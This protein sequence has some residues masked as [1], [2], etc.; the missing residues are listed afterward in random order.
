[1]TVARADAERI[2]MFQK[3]TGRAQYI[4]DLPIPPN[5]LYAVPVPSRYSHARIISI[6]SSQALALPGVVGIFDRDHLDGLDPRT[7]ISQFVASGSGGPS[8]R[9]AT[10]EH[11]IPTDRVRFDGE[12]V[13]M[14]V[15]EDLATARKAASLVDVR[16]EVL[17]T[18][19]SYDEALAPGAPSLHE[20]R[21][22]NVACEDSF[23]WGDVEAGLREAD[24][25]FETAYHG[26]MVYHH[27]MEPA[28]SCVTTVK[29]D[30]VDLWTSTHM[31][32]TVATELVARMLDIP[33]ENVRVRTPFIGGGFGAKEV[34]PPIMAAIALA[35]RTGR[36]VKYLAS[37]EASF[38]SNSRHDIEYRA[39][40]G[41]KKDGSLVALDVDLRMDTGAYF[42]GAALVAR[43]ACI[44]SWGCY[45]IPHFRVRAKNVF[46]NKVP[47]SAFRGTG[48]H[49]TTLGIEGV[50]D[51][52]AHRV[53]MTPR[54]IRERNVLRRGEKV[55]DGSWRVKGVEHPADLK[56]MDTDYLELIARV[57]DAIAWDGG[58]TKNPAGV[59]TKRGRG[60]AL[61]LRHGSQGGGRANAMVAMNKKGEVHVYHNAPDL[62][63]GTFNMLNVVASRALGVPRTLVTVHM[64][65]TANKL[66]FAGTSAQRTTVQIGNAVRLACENLKKEIASAAAQ[67][68]TGSE[69]DWTVHEGRVSRGSESHTFIEVM[70]RF[71][72]HGFTLSAMGSY[73]Y[74][75][76]QDRAFGGLDHWAPGAAAVE[77]EVDTDTGDVRV[78][79]IAVAS[80]AGV[81]LHLGSVLGQAIGGAIHGIGLALFEELRYEDGQLL[82]ADPFQ[83]RLPLISDIPREFS[84]SV[85]ENGDGPG[86]FGAKG[87]SQTTITA[88]APAVASAIEDATGA[89]LRSTPYT[90]DKLL[91]VLGVLK[92]VG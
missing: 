37:E 71:A 85:L 79:K 6:D 81:A 60:L 44:S 58:P 61:A 63:T 45:R 68:I 19:F 5:T 17:P 75:P 2:D 76:A 66:R 77:V 50:L 23:E 30:E 3:V 86:P 18:V 11:L 64:T 72:G 51:E 47:A 49:Q 84:A 57:A 4:D 89:R 88:I 27:P 73:S 22:D 54:A 82:N 15:A 46:T 26:G 33:A 8:P 1:M 90:P 74:R 56:P 13:A 41:V 36:P 34:N 65:D 48:K 62:G 67:A 10:E 29:G 12:M 24:I 80:D 78:S 42:T 39:R 21:P 7:P 52:A 70:D 20:D 83:Y 59:S 87:M 28:T 9:P 16:Y 43:N 40:V 31:P 91:R 53:G 38:R 14:V 69:S 25:V 35:R 55:H 32:Y 92:A